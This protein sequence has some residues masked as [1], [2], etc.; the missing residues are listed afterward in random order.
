MKY[1]GHPC[2]Y[3]TGVDTLDLAVDDKGGWVI[4]PASSRSRG[5]SV[6]AIASPCHGEDWGFES[7]HPLPLD[8][9]GSSPSYS[10]P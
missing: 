10:R 3:D 7:L 9:M 5:C 1:Y 2:C 8:R 4:I 6:T